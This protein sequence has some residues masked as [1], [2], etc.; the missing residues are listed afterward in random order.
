MGINGLLSSTTSLIE[1][2]TSLGLSTSSVRNIAEAGLAGNTKKI[3][4]VVGVLNRIVWFTGF[5]GSL[6]CLAFSS[7]LSEITFGNKDFAFSFVLISVTILFNQITAALGAVLRGL[8]Y[9]KYLA[10]SSVIGSILG[11]IVSVPLYYALGKDGIAPAILL[12]SIAT[13]ALAFFFY[14]KA[15]IR[16][17]FVK[18]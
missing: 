4:Q 8:R 1:A 3:S 13:L 12:T 6:F 5:V 10:Q 18:R 15:G 2:L 17:Q 16:S 14:R 11:L 7:W 9:V